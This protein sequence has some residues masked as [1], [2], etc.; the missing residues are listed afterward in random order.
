LTVV[1]SGARHT[2]IYELGACQASVGVR[3][4]E[5][6]TCHTARTGLVIATRLAQRHMIP[7][8]F[9]LRFVRGWDLASHTSLTCLVI[10]AARTV[11][12]PRRTQFT[13]RFVS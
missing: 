1:K 6:I 2:I 12:D 8:L 9:T 4:K 10:K 5:R 11:R 13:L 3:G 7:T